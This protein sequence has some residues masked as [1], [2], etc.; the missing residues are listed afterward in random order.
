MEKKKR[1]FLKY[2]YKYTIGNQVAIFYK[3]K[4]LKFGKKAVL[5]CFVFALE[6]YYDL[7]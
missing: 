7:L 3:G 5:F 2:F 4:S 1:F 6:Y